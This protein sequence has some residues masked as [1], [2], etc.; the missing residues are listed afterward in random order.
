MKKILLFAFVLI[1]TA[2]SAQ[3]PQ[4]TSTLPLTSTPLPIPTET[5]VPTITPTSTPTLVVFSP[6]TWAGTNQV[7]IDHNI[8]MHEWGLDPADYPCDDEGTCRD[9]EGKIISQNQNYDLN[10]LQ[11]VLVEAGLIGGPSMKPVM[12]SYPGEGMIPA[13]TNDVTVNFA[14]PMIAQFRAEFANKNGEGSLYEKSNGKIYPIMVD[15]ANHWGVVAGERVGEVTTFKFFIYR[16]MDNE[17]SVKWMSL[18]PFD[19]SLLGQY[20]RKF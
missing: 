15:E 17:K 20:R 9:K 13:P 2:C 7:R 19:A 1:L 3:Q 11:D 5:P 4:V 10:F 16:P 6:E 12:A 8:Q 14:A 18:I